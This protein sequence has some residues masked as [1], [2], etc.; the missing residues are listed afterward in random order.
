MSPVSE[1]S[2]YLCLDVFIW[3]GRLARFPRSR[4]FPT[5]ISGRGRGILPYDSSALL[6]GWKQDEFWPRW[7][8]LV[9]ACCI[10]RILSIAINCSDSA[11]RV[12]KA[13]I[14]AKF[15]I[16]VFRIS[17][18]I[19]PW[20]QNS[21]PGSLAFSSS[22][23]PGWN[24]SYEPKEKLVSLTGLIWRGRKSRGTSETG[25]R[26]QAYVSANQPKDFQ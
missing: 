2:P 25:L 1:I 24:F 18:F 23:K 22:S 6:P 11:L 13:M 9:F 3:Q 19:V 21:S 8:R 26:L 5:G 12:A 7:H 4:F 10:F 16:F 20:C 17:A 15:I 14:G